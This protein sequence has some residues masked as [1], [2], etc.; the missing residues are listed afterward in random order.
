MMNINCLSNCSQGPETIWKQNKFEKNLY[1][2]TVFWKHSVRKASTSLRHS[3]NQV[4]S[5][6]CRIANLSEARRVEGRSPRQISPSPL[7]TSSKFLHQ[8][9]VLGKSIVMNLK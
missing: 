3:K 4:S 7:F 2:S 5:K 1:F 8:L 6:I 9:K